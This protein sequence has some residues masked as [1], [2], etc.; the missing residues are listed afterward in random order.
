MAQI[1]GFR[2]CEPFCG[3][4]VQLR[5]KGETWFGNVVP[6][7]LFLTLDNNLPAL[8]RTPLGVPLFPKRWEQVPL[9]RPDG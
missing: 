4:E 2:H 7:L 9:Q 8:I 3:V 6:I 1:Q 5:Y